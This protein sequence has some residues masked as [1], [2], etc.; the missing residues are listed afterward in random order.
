MLK[1]NL[2]N[3]V[4]IGG[5]THTFRGTVMDV[6]FEVSNA[7]THPYNCVCDPFHAK[8][9]WG[10]T[11]QYQPT[12]QG[13]HMFTIFHIIA[14][15]N[16]WNCPLK[17]PVFHGAISSQ[18]ARRWSC[19][20]AWQ[21]RGMTT[22][23][24]SDFA[25][26]WIWN[27]ANLYR[28]KTYIVGG[29][30]FQFELCFKCY[31]FLDDNY[32]TSLFHICHL[33]IWNLHMQNWKLHSYLTTCVIFQLS[34]NENPNCWS[35]LWTISNVPTGIVP[36]WRTM[37]LPKTLFQGNFGLNDDLF[38][39]GPYFEAPAS[40]YETKWSSEVRTQQKQAQKDQEAKT[41]LC[42]QKELNKKQLEVEAAAHS[43]SGKGSGSAG[44]FPVPQ[45]QISRL[46]TSPALLLPK[47]SYALSRRV[48]WPSRNN[49][50]S[51][52]VLMSY[53]NDIIVCIIL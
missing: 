27:N 9:F 26:V 25:D 31:M 6:T 47:N 22:L 5:A 50:F 52:R 36:V 51:R 53:Q 13:F 43:V 49:R 12:R 48:G 14:R 18:L 11:L 15:H 39:S 34:I 45:A 4:N 16:M 1:I 17:S 37:G 2:R 21:T 41:N 19:W 35:K 29:L 40:K 24:R 28:R 3:L 7:E 10:N 8:T 44:A 33:V 42:Q 32:L 23:W 38:V 20:V 30:K 46:E